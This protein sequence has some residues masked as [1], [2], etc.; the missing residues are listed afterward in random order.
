MDFYL[1][2]TPEMIVVVLHMVK[3]GVKQPKSDAIP[4]VTYS[5]KRFVVCGYK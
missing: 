1:L 5:I 3:G 2:H 4:L